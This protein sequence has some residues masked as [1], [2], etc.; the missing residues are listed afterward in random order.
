MA[1]ILNSFV[2]LSTNVV[3]DW[4]DVKDYTSAILTFSAPVDGSAIIQWA[5]TQGRNIPTNN[6]IIATEY[7][8]YTSS[9]QPVTQ[10]WDHRARW[11]RV[12]YTQDLSAA[13]DFADMSF[14]LQTVYKR[15][16]TALKIV[17]NCANVVSVNVATGGN[18]LY[19]VLSDA[20]GNLIGTT[21]PAQTTGPALFVNLADSSGISLA[22]TEVA[23]GP[24]SLFVALRDASNYGI[25]STG[26]TAINN[27]LYIRPGDA[28][29]NA[30]AGTFA[31]QDAYT[32]GVALYAA[33]ADNCGVPITT[34]RTTNA[35]QSNNA[36]YVHLTDRYGRSIDINNPLPVINTVATTGA[37][38]FDVST[39]LQANFIYPE[40]DMSAIPTNGKLQLYNIF[41]YNDGA[42]TTWVRIYDVS[43]GAL[44]AA[45]ILAGVPNGIPATEASMSAL[46]AALGNPVPA[47]NLP[48]QA[49]RTRDLA[50]NGGST[51]YNGVAVQATTQGRLS[52]I[53]SPLQNSMFLNGSYVLIG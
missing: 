43:T 25:D 32:P 30:Q 19:T 24:Q 36:L 7:Y 31:V 1:S 12:S 50:L 10:Q 38:P 3:G 17:D 5:H 9:G 29:G 47:F 34:T 20:C 22:T 41:L 42:V 44:T 51:F 21:N 13:I 4:E 26:P 33:L 37:S 46:L 40:V 6:D 48:V 28:A 15:A 23:T 18:S 14:N 49:G 35:D 39:G 53:Q 11:F 45:Q 2:D 52:S 8:S 16:P 27:A